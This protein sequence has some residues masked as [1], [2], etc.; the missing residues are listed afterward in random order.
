MSDRAAAQVRAAV[1]VAAGLFERAK[2]HGTTTQGWKFAK[3]AADV[4]DRTRPHPVLTMAYRDKPAEQSDAAFLAAN[5]KF[6]EPVAPQEWPQR[7][8]RPGEWGEFTRVVRG[9]EEFL[10]AKPASAKEVARNRQALTEFVKRHAGV[11]AEADR[12]LLLSALEATPDTVT[13]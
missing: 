1:T 2:S 9:L 3:M 7:K 8:V 12:A 11:L 5:L 13:P 4:I 6:L 10:G